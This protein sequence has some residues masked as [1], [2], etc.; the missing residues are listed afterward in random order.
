M[1][2]TGL[3]FG[4]FNPI[5]NGHLMVAQYMLD[6]AGLD[7]IM[8]VVSPQNP[9][10]GE[11]ELWDAGKRLQLVQRCTA[12]NPGFRV[13]DIEF[14]LPRPGYTI[15]TL[16]ELVKLEPDTQF[17]IVMG[18]DNLS[19]FHTWN[20]PQEILE[21]AALLVYQRRGYEENPLNGDPRIRVFGHAPFIDISATY[22]RERLSQGKSVRYLVRDEILELL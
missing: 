5:H 20:Q 6:E 13:S 4:S 12:S 22:V 3:F 14:H 21:M 15:N 9:F 11:H 8:F 1:K 2:K 10:K 18:S 19:A 7:E 16:K 17:S